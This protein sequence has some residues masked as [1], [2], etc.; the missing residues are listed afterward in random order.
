LVFAVV[1]A[2]VKV[3][4]RQ[5][6]GASPLVSSMIEILFPVIM[7]V[8]SAIRSWVGRRFGGGGG[9]E[10]GQWWRWLLVF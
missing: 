7:L 8:A 10:E 2:A 1:Y 5:I 6:F 9:E 3:S 4:V